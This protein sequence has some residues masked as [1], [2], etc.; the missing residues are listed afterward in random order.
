M[1]G[2]TIRC[3]ASGADLGVLNL[4]NKTVV[5]NGGRTFIISPEPTMVKCPC[6]KENLIY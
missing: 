5:L 2:Q 6:G 1:A 3:T 4:K